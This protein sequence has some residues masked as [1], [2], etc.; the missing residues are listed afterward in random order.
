MAVGHHFAG[1]RITWPGQ[2]FPKILPFGIFLEFSD[3]VPP[4]SYTSDS[5]DPMLTEFLDFICRINGEH[6]HFLLNLMGVEFNQ[7]KLQTADKKYLTEPT[8]IHHVKEVSVHCPSL[9]S[10]CSITVFELWT[11]VP[12]IWSTV[13]KLNCQ[14]NPLHCSAPDVSVHEGKRER[15]CKSAKTVDLIR[16]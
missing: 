16:I 1:R 2:T 3:I 6:G 12:V 15:V 13:L 9:H 5:H 7:K 11:H 4:R 14:N 10:Q 8:C